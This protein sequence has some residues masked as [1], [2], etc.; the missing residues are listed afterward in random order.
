MPRKTNEDGKNSVLSRGEPA[1]TS[2]AAHLLTL[3]PY[4]S[5]LSV[6][7]YSYRSAHSPS[8]K[9]LP[10]RIY[11]PIRMALFRRGQKEVLGGPSPLPLPAG[12]EREGSLP[13]HWQVQLRTKAE[14]PFREVSEQTAPLVD[15]AFGG[16]LCSRGR[17]RK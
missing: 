11:A 7:L 17:E 2:C 5:R 13:S 1:Q 15:P 8:Y 14:K 3:L 6:C 10:H 12:T 16:S 9:Y 4:H